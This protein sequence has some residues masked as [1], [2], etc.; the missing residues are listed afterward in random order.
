MCPKLPHC[1]KLSHVTGICSF[2]HRNKGITSFSV[3]DHELSE[4]QILKYPK[5]AQKI[6]TGPLWTLL[7]LFDRKKFLCLDVFARRNIHGAYFTISSNLRKVSS[8]LTFPE[9]KIRSFVDSIQFILYTNQGD[10]CTNLHYISIYL[11][12]KTY[13]FRIQPKMFLLLIYKFVRE[14]SRVL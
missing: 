11:T 8:R 5:P 7:R 13:T 10:Q 4:S 3:D 6:L 14:Y 12:T 2:C 1:P 9:I